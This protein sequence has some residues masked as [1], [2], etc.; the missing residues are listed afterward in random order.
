MMRNN[1]FNNRT[2]VLKEKYDDV[3]YRESEEDKSTFH[4]Y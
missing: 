3:N 4:E 1:S 2:Y